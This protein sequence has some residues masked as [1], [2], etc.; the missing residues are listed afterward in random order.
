M[1]ARRDP[2]EPGRVRA[3]EPASLCV[4]ECEAEQEAAVADVAQRQ[5]LATATAGTVD[6]A[7]GILDDCHVE[8]LYA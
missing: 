3:D 5:R 7:K 6:L 1:L 4:V 8:L 2:C